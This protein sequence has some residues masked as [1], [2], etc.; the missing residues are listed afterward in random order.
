MDVERRF[1]IVVRLATDEQL[2][3]FPERTQKIKQSLEKVA[4]GKIGLA[5]SSASA[6]T[7]GLFVKTNRAAAQLRAMIESSQGAAGDTHIMVL[8]LGDQF[9]AIGNSAGWRWLQH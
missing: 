3:T 7:L 1:L 6:E 8:E 5:F 2:G 4:I 9:A